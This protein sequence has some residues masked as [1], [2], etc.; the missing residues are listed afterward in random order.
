MRTIYSARAKFLFDQF[1]MNGF[2]MNICSMIKI[3]FASE[4][5]FTERTFCNSCT[6][7]NS[8]TFPMVVLNN[9]LFCNDFS[10][11]EIAVMGNFPEK[12]SCS[13]CRGDIECKREFGSHMFIEVNIIIIY[14]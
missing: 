7:S 12:L 8:S 14:Y 13:R 3:L 10:H 5:S 4:P 6:H 11:L 9:R 1:N 2:E